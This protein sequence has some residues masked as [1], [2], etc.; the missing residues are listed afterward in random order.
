MLYLD[1]H[2]QKARLI[3]LRTLDIITTGDN[4]FDAVVKNNGVTVC[5][6]YY[7]DNFN[8]AYD[9][10]LASIETP[11]VPDVLRAV[12]HRYG[13]QDVAFLGSCSDAFE[14]AYGGSLAVYTR[15]PENHLPDLRTEQ[16]EAQMDKLFAMPDQELCEAV[17]AHFGSHMTQA[18]QNNLKIWAAESLKGNGTLQPYQQD[19]MGCQFARMQVQEAAVEDTPFKDDPSFL[20]RTGFVKTAE[21]NAVSVYRMDAV[22]LR[23]ADES[24]SITGKGADG[25]DIVLGRLPDRFLRKNPMNVNECGAKLQLT[26]YSN[27]KMKNVTLRAVM[28]VDEMSGDVIC[29]DNDMLPDVSLNDGLEIE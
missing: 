23:N 15:N 27:G 16:V 11:Y 1:Q 18:G 14:E 17:N 24:V 6:R 22:L 9:Q 28:N 4:T 13:V 25:A 20:G 19:V 29:L 12:I 2:K 5:E 10:A 26:D 21:K 3:E 8:C 7:S